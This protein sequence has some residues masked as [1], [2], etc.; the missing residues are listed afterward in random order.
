MA[1]EEIKNIAGACYDH[2][3]YYSYL[4]TKTLQDQGK[5]YS[6]LDLEEI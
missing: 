6:E 4:T 2:V 1:A 5:T 3:Q